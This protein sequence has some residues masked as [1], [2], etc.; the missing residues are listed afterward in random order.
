MQEIM[1]DYLPVIYSNAIKFDPLVNVDFTETFERKI[2]GTTENTGTLN[3]NGTSNSNSSSQGNNLNI[4][5]NTPQT[6]IKKQDL[7]SGLYASKVEQNNSDNNIKD[8]TITENQNTTSNNGTSNQIENYT[9]TTKGKSGVSA[10]AQAQIM[11][12]RESIRAVDR[13][14]IES[15]NDLFIGLY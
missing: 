12:Y 7:E 10:T 8:T 13:E 6:N 2:D 14:I 11:Q 3:S 4:V 15:L 9:K 5:N 1:E